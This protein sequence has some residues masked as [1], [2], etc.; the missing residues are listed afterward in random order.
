[1]HRQFVREMPEQVNKERTWE[2]MRN[3]SL[4]GETEALIVMAQE[5]ALKTTV[6][7]CNIDK[8]ENN[9]LCIICGE[10]NETDTHLVCACKVLAQKEYKRRHENI[11]RIVHWELCGR[12]NL[13]RVDKWCGHHP[14]GVLEN[15]SVKILWDM[16]I[17]CDHHIEARRPDILVMEKD[18]KKALIID[19]AS[20]RDHNVVGKESENAE[21]HQ[22]LKREIKKL[23]NLRRAD[24]IPVLADALGSDQ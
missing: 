4:K 16:T 15:E 8:T 6:V 12:Y 21:K 10:K 19:I 18:S 9:P 2:W 23:W 5:Y 22:D 14:N 17:Q 20:S 1:M 7:K 24:V 11:A 13:G 3:S